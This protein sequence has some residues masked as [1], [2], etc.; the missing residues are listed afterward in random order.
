[1]EHRSM[2]KMRVLPL[3]AV[4]FMASAFLYVLMTGVSPDVCAA[5]N[6]PARTG[7]YEINGREYEQ[8][9]IIYDVPN[10]DDASRDAAVVYF[11]NRAV[12]PSYIDVDG[13]RYTVREIRESAAQ[14]D[15]DDPDG[16]V[17]LPATLKRA[18]ISRGYLRDDISFTYGV[19]NVV[20]SNLDSFLN[21][22][23]FEQNYKWFIGEDKLGGFSGNWKL[24]LNGVEL[25]DYDYVYPEGSTMGTNL[26]GLL[27]VRSITVP[28]SDTTRTVPLSWT[29][30][31]SWDPEPYPKKI[32]FKANSGY[33]LGLYGIQADTLAMPNS[34]K[35]FSGYGNSCGQ[36]FTSITFKAVQW[37][38]CM[39]ILSS[40]TGL[41]E[42]FAVKDI[43]A[44]LIQLG[45]FDKETLE[46]GTSDTLTIPAHLDKIENVNFKSSC[47]LNSVNLEDSDEPLNISGKIQ[48]PGAVTESSIVYIGRNIL[49]KDENSYI[50][51]G[52][53]NQ[54]TTIILGEK[55]NYIP[56]KFP[57]KIKLRESEKISPKTL[58]CKG[59][60]PPEFP[61][62]KPEILKWKDNTKLVVPE[63]AVEAYRNHPV[64]RQFRTIQTT[65]ADQIQ[66]E[67]VVVS[68]RW[69]SLDG[70]TLTAPE[71][72]RI[73]I[74][75]TTYSDGTTV[76]RKVAVP[77]K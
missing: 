26:L 24:Y 36:M 4:A 68:E 15:I 21:M 48:T 56:E 19:H 14:T 72:G 69:I 74:Q 51:Y 42:F 53:E 62:E 77:A 22:E 59:L 40:T 50:R 11:P 33:N 76:S 71:T 60:T 73:N 52:A 43:P 13:V 61:T 63:A 29:N 30:D 41:P 45:N 23:Q 39:E 1:M 20:I 28:A 5:T 58:I 54:T 18:V 3:C 32:Q 46:I 27:G 7:D 9:G 55:V 34:L 38:D 17:T 16:W 12:I 25:K 57:I 10:V 64:W 2:K 37:S 49:L 75:V 65:A 31:W 35:E 6:T 67:R 8:D 44:T 70:R 66:M 47:R